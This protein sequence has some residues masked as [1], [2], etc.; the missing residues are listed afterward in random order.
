MTI[1]DV[2]RREQTWVVVDS[3]GER[4]IRF[5]GLLTLLRT[6]VLFRPLAWLLAIWPFASIGDCCYRLVARH[7]DFFGRLASV[8]P[9]RRSPVRPYWPVQPLIVALMVYVVLY[10]FI[11]L[12]GW[13]MSWFTK[14]KQV[15]VFGQRIEIRPKWIYNT[16]HH[17]RLDQ[18]WKLFAPKP[19]MGDGWF[20][21][22]GTFADGSTVE[23]QSGGAVSFDKPAYV[24][25]TY[26]NNRWR[27]FMEKIRRENTN[28]RFQLEYCKYLCRRWNQSHPEDEQLESVKLYFM[29]ELSRPP[30]IETT[31]RKLDLK[32]CECSTAWRSNHE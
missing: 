3:A 27:K 4:H 16:G 5:D 31:A 20:V 6:S 2:I 11:S 29:Y 30:H 28:P 23:A 21:A 13:D 22:V 19:L 26:P 18:N 32:S 1:D 15:A 24:A 10:N 9:I 14:G 8:A 12:P 7:R 25:Y 17:L